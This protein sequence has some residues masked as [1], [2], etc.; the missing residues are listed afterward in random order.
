MRGTFTHGSISPS[1]A[2]IKR[3]QDLAV[4]GA[5][6][7]LLGLQD[8]SGQARNAYNSLVSQFRSQAN[9]QASSRS[10]L[11]LTGGS[12]YLVNDD[13]PDWNH[14]YNLAREMDG[15]KSK[16]EIQSLLQ[17]KLNELKR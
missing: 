1:Y 14:V 11:G 7:D 2:L 3:C 13:L 8:L 6:A 17:N 12:T 16:Y 15:N 10:W 9:Q 4:I 5:Y